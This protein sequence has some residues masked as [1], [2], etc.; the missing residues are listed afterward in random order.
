MPKVS[1]I[2]N[3]YNSEEYLR[4]ALDSIKNQTY[5]DYEV[6]FIDNCSTDNS[7]SIA[8]EFGDK[9]KYYKTDSIIP[10][11]AGRN[12]GIEHCTGEYIAFLD[13][14]D[15]WEKEK[16]AIQVRIM[17]ENPKCSITMSNIY[18]LNM[19][20]KNRTVAIHKDVKPV[21]DL[22][23]FGIDY[24]FGMSSFMIRRDIVKRMSFRFDERLSYAEEYDF[25][26]RLA[27]MGEIRYTSKVLSTYRVH[28]NMNS[29][30][31]KES[32]PEEYEIVRNNLVNS[33][34]SVEKKFPELI[35]YLLFL[36][37]YTKT[38]ICIENKRNSEARKYIKPYTRKYKK[39]K[40]FYIFS[41]LPT[42]IT[43]W[44]FKNYYS[45][46]VV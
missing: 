34:D 15:F 36:K 7:A 21:L 44:I 37:D 18:M 13:C 43:Q 4:E 19:D 31:L 39:A 25:F 10:L 38:K 5:N 27:C 8:K 41:L 3:C 24:E 30:K 35:S 16:L 42:F 20:D 14:D 26:M 9:L 17:D 12:F 40:L 45:H 1:I 46:K 23:E 33:C 11:G 6:V 2:V 22:Q 32:I 28:K 29:R